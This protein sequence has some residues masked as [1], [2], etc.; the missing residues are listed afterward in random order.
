MAR[1]NVYCV[2]SHSVWYVITWP[3]I[4]ILFER[5]IDCRIFWYLRL[6]VDGWAEDTTKP[7]QFKDYYYPN[8]QPGR[9]LWYHD[10]AINHTAEK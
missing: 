2:R 3:D 7:G 4:V 1:S 6:T 8:A 9:T 10:H 5:Q